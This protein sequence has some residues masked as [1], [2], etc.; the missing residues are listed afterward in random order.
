MFDIYNRIKTEICRVG[1]K[2]K[3][4]EISSKKTRETDLKNYYSDYVL[5]IS[6]HVRYRKPMNLKLQNNSN[7]YTLFSTKT[8]LFS[9]LNGQTALISN[10]NQ[11]G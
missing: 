10:K 8:K 9:I 11:S 4:L 1:N 7:I 6:C 3:R 5:I 2:H